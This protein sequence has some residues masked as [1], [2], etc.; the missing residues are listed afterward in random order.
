MKAVVCSDLH[1]D[2]ITHGVRRH[3]EIRDALHRVIDAAIKEKVDAF[4]CLGDV[5]NPDAGSCVFRVMATMLEAAGRLRQHDIRQVWIAGNHDVIEDGTG[6]TTLTPLRSL[7]EVSMFYVAELPRR[8]VLGDTHVICLPFT[9]TSHG[10]NVDEKL[11]ELTRS[12]PR[13]RTIILSHLAV[14][15][16]EPGEETKEMPRGREVK[17]A[18]ARAKLILQGHYHR[19]QRMESVWVAGSLARLTFCEERHDPGYLIVEV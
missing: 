14:P 10:Y 13:E 5:A 2:W 7:E 9:A 17:L 16:I 4:F 19:Q 8:V 3:D 11:G 12:S 15:G 1:L 18:T 6:D